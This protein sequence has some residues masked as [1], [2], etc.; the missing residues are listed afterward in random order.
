M[1]LSDYDM[2]CLAK[3]KEIMDKDHSIHYDIATLAKKVGLGT[4]KLKAGF[5]LLY[6]K[7]LYQY[8]QEQRMQHA[9][10]ILFDKT[11]T[12]KQVAKD[13]G[14]KHTNNFIAAFSKKFG[15]SPGQIKK[16]AL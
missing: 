8:L 14:F 13:V 3:A 4:T 5:K 11:K 2:E 10:S 1:L 7:G 16:Q 12:L 9:M 6:G 15:I